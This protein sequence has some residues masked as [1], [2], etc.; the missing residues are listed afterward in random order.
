MT[1]DERAIREVVETWIAASKAGDL[2]KVLSLVADDVIFMVC[3]QEPFGKAA[4]ARG[5]AASSS[6]QIDG[7]STVQEIQVLGDWAYLRNHL[8]VT[9]TPRD[10]GEPTRRAGYTLTILRKQPGGNWV[11][12]RDANLMTTAR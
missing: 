10:S 12:V 8:T 6:M 11:L 2:A 3:G 7:T 5:F 9:V 4:F 1:D